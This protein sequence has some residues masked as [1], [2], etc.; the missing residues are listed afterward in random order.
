[1][2][3]STLLCSPAGRMKCI[4]YRQQG[5]VKV[6]NERPCNCHRPAVTIGNDDPKECAM[7]PY[8]ERP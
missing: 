4:E 7:Y 2:H 8:F 6:V 1:M 5:K 3:N